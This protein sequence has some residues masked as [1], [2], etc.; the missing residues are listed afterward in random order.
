MQ[1]I[2]EGMQGAGGHL[3]LRGLCR[4]LDRMRAAR[5]GCKSHLP[6]SLPA[7]RLL[8][9]FAKQFHPL[10]INTEMASF[11][12]RAAP[13]T[14]NQRRETKTHFDSD[15]QRE[16]LLFLIFKPDVAFML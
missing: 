4:V 12:Q 3:C 8:F 6:S 11:L 2:K 5:S 14:P 10:Q 13:D 1:L 7:P 9:L 15:E 16:F